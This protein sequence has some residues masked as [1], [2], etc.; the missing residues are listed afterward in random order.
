MKDTV[1][2]NSGKYNYEYIML[3]AVWNVYPGVTFSDRVVRCFATQSASSHVRRGI[4]APWTY[5]LP[6]GRSVSVSLSWVVFWGSEL[7]S[8]LGL[9][10]FAALSR[11]RTCF[12][13]TAEI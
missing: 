5:L 7:R 4:R 1:L 11:R 8:S 10:L 6:I 2:Y 9:V 3:W 13:S 12:F